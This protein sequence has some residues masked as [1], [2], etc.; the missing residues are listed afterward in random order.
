L[1]TGQRG[2]GKITTRPGTPSWPQGDNWGNSFDKLGELTE[3]HKLK[4]TRAWNDLPNKGGPRSPEGRGDWGEVNKGKG[5]QNWGGKRK[6][7]GF[8][9]PPRER[10]RS[11]VRRGF[12]T[13]CAEQK[14][15]LGKQVGVWADRGYKKEE[16]G[17]NEMVVKLPGDSGKGGVRGRE[18]PGVVFGQEQGCRRKPFSKGR[19]RPQPRGGRFF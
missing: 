13:R 12:S 6:K 16:N 10:K 2:V 11:N 5:K 7:C 17:E 9:R 14:K 1:K 3:R 18:S 15:I 19:N 8:A 4:K